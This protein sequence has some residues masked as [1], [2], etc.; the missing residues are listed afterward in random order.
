MELNA[1]AASWGLKLSSCR[2][3]GSIGLNLLIVPR[4]R[5]GPSGLENCKLF[6]KGGNYRPECFIF[7]I[8][9]LL[10]CIIKEAV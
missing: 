3:S 7:L 10:E 1:D 5:K 6:K 9:K 4:F 2:D 8:C